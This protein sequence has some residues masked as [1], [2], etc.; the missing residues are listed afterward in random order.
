[1][2]GATKAFIA[3]VLKRSYSRISGS[4]SDDVQTMRSCNLPDQQ[5]LGASFVHGIEVGVQEADRDRRHLLAP[6][7]LG[8]LQHLFIDQR[9]HH[10]TRGAQPLADLEA[11]MARHQ[12]RRPH[13]L[14]VEH[15][16]GHHASAAAD[17]ERVAEP[18]G[19]DQGDLAPVPSRTVLVATVVPC[20]M[21]RIVAKSSRSPA[22]PASTPAA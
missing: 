17:L 10:R 8:E 7:R 11:Q 12:R 20:T 19:G 22:M 2:T 3:V 16:V 5:V 13:E 9:P 15:A 6:D 1:M 18:R 21:R 4:I 14:G